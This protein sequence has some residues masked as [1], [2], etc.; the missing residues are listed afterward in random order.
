MRKEMFQLK[1]IDVMVAVVLGLGFQWWPELKE[2]WQYLAF[3]FAYLNLIDYWIDYNPTAKKFALKLEA[4]V[5]LH[6]IIIFSMFL[7]VF[8][9]QKSLWY[10]FFAFTFYR[11]ADI[12]WLWF[13]K[14]KHKTLGEDLIFIHTWLWSDI[15]E[16]LAAL[17]FGFLASR[18]LFGPL[19]LLTAFV[20][21]R[22]VTRAISSLRY[23]KIF[24]AF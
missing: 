16:A 5:V 3:A 22:I 20:L 4:D 10:F 17:G 15:V 24:Y 18:E 21:V 11:M 9:T 1:F 2:P 13:I 8:A 23:K 6:T 19:Y 7:L 12:V 14:K